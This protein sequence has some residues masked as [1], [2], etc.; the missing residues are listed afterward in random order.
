VTANGQRAVSG[1]ADKTLKVWDLER[2]E[3][4]RTLEGHSSFLIAVAVTADGKWA[5]SGSWDNTLKVWDLE[6]GE[7]VRTLE[8]HADRVLA[9]AVTA[10][11]KWAVS[12]SRDN[13]LKVWDLQVGKEI[14]AFGADRDVTAC[15]V[16]TNKRMFIAGEASG[17]VHF[18]KLINDDRDRRPKLLK[19]ARKNS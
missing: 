9:M 12:G 13:T 7:A 18:L 19:V 10:D 15:A 14:A 3:A 17:C 5:V 16:S 1:S 4:V 2:G 11:G 8:G 6:R